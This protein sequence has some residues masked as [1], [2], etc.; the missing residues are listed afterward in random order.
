MKSS[1]NENCSWESSREHNEREMNEYKDSVKKTDV[2][3]LLVS[4]L[5]GHA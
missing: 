5:F 2:S 4:E 1:K 3:F